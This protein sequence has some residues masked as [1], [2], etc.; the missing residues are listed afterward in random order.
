MPRKRFPAV[1]PRPHP[2]DDAAV[3]QESLRIA[4]QTV[5][6]TADILER[7]FPTSLLIERLRMFAESCADV[8]DRLAQ[9]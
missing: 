8:R 6:E 2:T 3:V 7:R 9:S 1:V 5:L 4:Q